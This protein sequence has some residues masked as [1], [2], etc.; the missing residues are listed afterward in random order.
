MQPSLSSELRLACGRILPLRAFL[1]PMEGIMTHR[2][3][4]VASALGLLDLWM[5]PFVSVPA[6]SVPSRAAIRR[7]LE[8]FTESSLPVIPQI[9]GR[10]AEAVAECAKRMAS[11]GYEF[12]SL[13]FACPSPAVLRGGSGGA[14]LKKPA[15]LLEILERTVLALDGSASVIVKLRNGW[16]LPG[17]MESLL[18]AI[19]AAG[20][21]AC[22]LHYRTVMEKYDN[23]NGGLERLCRSVELAGE[24]PVIGNGDIKS[25]EDAA[26][27]CLATNC[28]GVAVARGFLSDPFLLRRVLGHEAPSLEKGRSLFLDAMRKSESGELL[29]GNLLEIAKAMYGENSERFREML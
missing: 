9:L 28:A 13:N 7:R 29:K 20:A 11:L 8:F 26:A 14:L 12:I 5:A 23:V 18:P 3:V 1:A 15:L 25:L 24:M 4:M 17:E 21:G 6:G 27:M 10:D 2:F 22:I 16:A 19:R